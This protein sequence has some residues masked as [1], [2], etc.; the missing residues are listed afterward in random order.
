[1]EF[2]EKIQTTLL[3]FE[4]REFYRNIGIYFGIVL[5]LIF[6]LMYYYFSNVLYLKKELKKT[7]IKREEVQ[8]ILR[9]LKNVTKQSQEV[10]AVLLEDKDFKIKKFFDDIIEQQNIKSKQKREA[11]VSEEVL[12]KRY[13]EIKLTAQF[14]QMNT[15][16]LCDLLNAIEQKARVYTKELSITKAKGASLDVSLTIATLK[17]QNETAKT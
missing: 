1:M 2:L 5:A 11:E 16:L 7:K 12:Y 6:G 13:T 8:L 17:P 4:K 3:R 14:R 9:K 10:N 15:K